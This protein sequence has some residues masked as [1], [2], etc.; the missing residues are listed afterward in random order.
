M[1]LIPTDRRLTQE[2]LKFEASLGY[3]TI[4]SLKIK[5]NKESYI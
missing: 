4:L 5:Q 2:A 3:E 1:S